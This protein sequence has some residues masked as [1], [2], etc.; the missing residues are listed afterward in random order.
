MVKLL[1]HL[2]NHLL[3][4]ARHQDALLAHSRQFFSRAA[5]TESAYARYNS[6]A[7][8]RRRKLVEGT[9][10]SLSRCSQG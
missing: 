8:L 9:L 7:Y 4:F 6:P 10:P 1:E 5:Y 2:A 3:Q